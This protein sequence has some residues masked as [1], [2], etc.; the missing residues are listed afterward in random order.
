MVLIATDPEDAGMSSA[1]LRKVTRLVQRYVDGRKYAGAVSLVARRG[2]VVHFETY[3]EMDAERGKPMRPD[4]IFRVYSMTKP[5]ASVALMMLYQEG[6]FQL[7]DPV[8]DFLPEL[9]DLKVY[10]GGDAD[11]FETREPARRMTVRDLLMHT[12]GLGAPRARTTVGELY[13]RAGIAA[14][15]SGGTLAEMAAK[16]GAIPLECDPGARWIY[17]VSTDLVGYLCEVLSGVP[18]DRYLKDRIFTPLGMTDTGFSVPESEAE[19]LAAV[20][21]PQPGSP[22]FTLLEDPMTSPFLRPRTYFSGVSG[23]VS[24]AGD[25]LRFC[26]MLA[27]GGEVDGVRLLGPRTL[28]LMTANHLPGGQDLE[29]MTHDGGETRREGQGF[30]LGFGVLLDQTVAQTIGT[31]GEIF[32]GGAASTA[33]FVSPEDDLI[34]IFLTQLRPSATYPIRRELRATVYSSIID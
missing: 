17:G 19:R 3:G 4:T 33:F 15:E 25:Y 34:T 5:I 26:R 14:D 31:P 7:N 10:A 9:R 23:L 27:G 16:L 2:K 13:R 1:G 11:R 12:S 21:A 22:R 24:T 8:A 20:Y 32:W 6:L 29:T 18:F 28:R 30:G